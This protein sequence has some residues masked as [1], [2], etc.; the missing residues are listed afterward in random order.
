MEKNVK[1][2]ITEAAEAFDAELHTP[3]YAE[4]HADATQLERLLQY[5]TVQDEQSL[6]DLGTGA[7][8]VALALARCC[9]ASKVIGLDIA[10]QAID[11][12][13]ALVVE[14]DLHNVRF[15][16]FGGVELPFEDDFFDGVISRFAF[17]H[18]P[19]RDVT[20]A[21]LSRV[22]RRSGLLVVADAV[23]SEVDDVDFIN[24]FQHLKQD[25]HI[26]MLRR[27]NFVALFEQ[28]GFS[29][30]DSFSSTL[31]FQRQRGPAYDLLINNTPDPVLDAYRLELTPDQMHLTF[32]IFNAVFKN[33]ASRTAE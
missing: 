14:K 33:N 19:R 32:P 23:R 11:R 26:E 13:N 29:L 22:M 25:G 16:V 3:D 8:Y 24:D 9:P 5:L 15:Q 7:G 4:T 10:E 20:L 27:L 21:E 1:A 2:L 6:L 28:H 17:H 18:F 31:S 30:H 12:N